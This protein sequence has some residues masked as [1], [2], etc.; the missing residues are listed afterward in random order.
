MRNF[1]KI[2]IN[3]IKHNLQLTV[4][5]KKA[6]AVLKADAYGHGA[7]RV[8]QALDG[9]ALAF[10]VSNIDEAE[11]ISRVAKKTPVLILGDGYSPEFERA[12]DTGTIVSLGKFKNAL[13]LD[14]LAR[15]KN[16]KAR[17]VLCIDTG[18]RR[19]GFDCTDIHGIA[20]ALELKNIDILGLYSHPARSGDDD[21]TAV[22]LARFN[23][24]KSVFAGRSD[25][26]W[27]FPSSASL[28]ASD[29]IARVGLSLYGLDPSKNPGVDLRPALTFRAAILS[30]RRVKK[31]EYIGYGDAFRA[32]RDMTVATVAAGYA[33]GVPRALSNKGFVLLHSM[34][35][36][37]VGNICMDA[38]MIDVSDIPF[39][40]NE[41]VTLIGRDGD[42]EITAYDVAR[43][44]GTISYEILC[45]ISNRVPRIYTEKDEEN[46]E[47]QMPCDRP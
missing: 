33:D 45:G 4:A 43:L 3:A 34:R 27:S 36:K 24:I 47:I 30:S 2:D 37:I 22:Q 35:A 10:A 32:E 7:A 16:I 9:D 38:L 6:V 29:D 40:T 31:G 5:N 8:A 25:L 11:E 26:F 19:D 42:E 46:A 13:V 21:F 41:Y 44:C 14:E 18:M 23:K 1:A 39:Y 28:D 17:A 12:I 20:A 15:R